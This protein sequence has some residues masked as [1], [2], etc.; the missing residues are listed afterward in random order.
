MTAAI[1]AYM[2]AAHEGYMQKSFETAAD[3]G[4][5]TDFTHKF[6]K[7]IRA[8]GRPGRIHTG[9][10]TGV[11]HWGGCAF[12]PLT[13]TKAPEELFPF[14]CSWKEA[15]KIGGIGRLRYHASDYLACDGSLCTSADTFKEEL[16]QG[17]ILP[18]IPPSLNCPRASLSDD[19]YVYANTRQDSIV[20]MLAGLS[21]L[22][23]NTCDARSRVAGIA[24]EWN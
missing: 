5:A 14:I 15:R 2:K 10:F 7:C 8:S 16:E 22:R 1:N 3:E 24:T 11:S 4:I 21:L 20:L 18:Y 9:S 13:F 12:S 17:I 23:N 6:S 19:A